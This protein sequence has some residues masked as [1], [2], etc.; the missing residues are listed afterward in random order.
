MALSRRCSRLGEDLCAR[1]GLL[2]PSKGPAYPASQIPGPHLGS[3]PCPAA[4][5]GAAWRPAASPP[6]GSPS[7]SEE[8]QGCSR[9][10]TLGAK[11]LPRGG[12]V[13]ASAVGARCS[14]AGQQAGQKSEHL[15]EQD[16]G[17]AAQGGP[18]PPTCFTSCTRMRRRVAP[19]A[20]VDSLSRS[21][22][23]ASRRRCVAH[24]CEAAGRRDGKGTGMCERRSR[25]RGGQ[26]QHGPAAAA[27]V[28][29]GLRAGR[30]PAEAFKLTNRRSD[31]FRPRSE[32]WS[33][34]A[35]TC[36]SNLRAGDAVLHLSDRKSKRRGQG[37]AGGEGH[38][39][40]AR[41]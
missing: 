2:G 23:Q 1:C 28:K 37:W 34:S 29:Q 26:L 40:K 14:Q 36:S 18:L 8:A 24:E 21:C 25:G 20:E 30:R 16:E 13:Q 32:S 41:A 31:S 4:G 6:A 9:L 15:V 3:L 39:C 35:C 17:C 33:V 19:S 22:R 27:A 12:A 38:G 5:S 10:Y 11:P 7:A